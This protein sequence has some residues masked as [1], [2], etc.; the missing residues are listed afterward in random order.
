MSSIHLASMSPSNTIHFSSSLTLMRLSLHCLYT[1]DSIPSIQSPV[2]V[3]AYPYS[4]ITGLSFGLIRQMR[5]LMPSSVLAFFSASMMVDLP[6][7]V[8]PTTIVVCL[9]YIVSYMW[10]VLFT[11]C[12]HSDSYSSKFL[13]SSRSN[14]L[15]I[16]SLMGGKSVL[17]MS[18][19]A[20]RP[21][22]RLKNSS[23]S[24]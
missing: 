5:V 16:V 7:H 22:I 6:A 20:N 9:V 17:V 21:S 19:L 3:L 1:L 4:S 14:I 2:S 24:S 18:T 11:W 10:I 23:W 8:G 12:M 15:I 13:L